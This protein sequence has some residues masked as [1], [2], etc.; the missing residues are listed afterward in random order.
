MCLYDR[1]SG[2][3][4]FLFPYTTDNLEACFQDTEL[5]H[6]QPNTEATICLLHTGEPN[7]G[8]YRAHDVFTPDICLSVLYGELDYRITKQL[9]AD[10][11]TRPP[12]E[13]KV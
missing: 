2:R 13:E 10:A 8:F 4:T 9:L 3:M 12:V 5:S 1:E 6:W 11:S 7:I